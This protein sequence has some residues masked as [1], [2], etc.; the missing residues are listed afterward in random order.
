MSGTGG[1]WP[2]SLGGMCREASRYMAN[3]FVR[4][5]VFRGNYFPVLRFG[6]HVFR[7]LNLKYLS[8]SKNLI[9]TLWVQS[10]NFSRNTRQLGKERK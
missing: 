8:S 5:V 2:L 4:T 7:L 3:I 6:V 9:L 1:R 10:P